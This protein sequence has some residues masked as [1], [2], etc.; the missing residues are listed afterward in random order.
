MEER[1][2]NLYLISVL[3]RINRAFIHLNIYYQSPRRWLDTCRPGP[4]IHDHDI[5]MELWYIKET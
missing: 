5:H 1:T 3:F 4:N 2:S